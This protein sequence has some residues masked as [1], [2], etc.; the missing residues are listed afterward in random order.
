[1]VALSR[2]RLVRASRS[3]WVEETSYLGEGEGEG[4]GGGEGEGE[5]G[6]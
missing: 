4:E 5:G 3:C 6:A 2:G 1:M